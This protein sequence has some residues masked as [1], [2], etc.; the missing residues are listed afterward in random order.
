M[1]SVDAMLPMKDTK[2]I[3]KMS[4][5]D[6]VLTAMMPQVFKILSSMYSCHK[7]R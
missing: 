2:I 1:P 7:W 3:N 5:R 6:I 4:R